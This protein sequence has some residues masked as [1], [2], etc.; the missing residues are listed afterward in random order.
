MSG[1][2]FEPKGITTFAQAALQKQSNSQLV[3]PGK[4]RAVTHILICNT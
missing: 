4:S 1:E 3:L 2:Q